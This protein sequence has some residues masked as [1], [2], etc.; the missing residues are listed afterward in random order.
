MLL[1]GIGSAI[2]IDQIDPVFIP[3]IRIRDTDITNS[4]TSW[5]H[6]FSFIIDS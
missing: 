3:V 6:R 1:V 5:F 4:P 2:L